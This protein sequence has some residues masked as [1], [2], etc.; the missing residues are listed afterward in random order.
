MKNTLRILAV[1]MVAVMLCLTLA[2]CGGPNPDP[3]KALESLKENGVTFA[4]KDTL[5][6]PTALKVLGVDG[7][8][9]VV[10]GTGKIDDKY[11]HVTII[12]FEEAEDANNAFEKVEDYA[13][14]KKGDAEDSDWV[15][16][17]SGKMIYYGT[18]DAVKAAK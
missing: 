18:K 4:G 6:I 5:V 3:D 8:S 10:S 16:K 1:A 9:S 12:Y 14:G 2:S 15:F 11:A 13:D 17:K 7:I